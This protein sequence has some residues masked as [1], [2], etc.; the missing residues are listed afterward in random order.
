M[1]SNI[2][3]SLGKANAYIAS[4]RAAVEPEKYLYKLTLSPTRVCTTIQTAQIASENAM[5][6]KS[7]SITCQM[8]LETTQINHFH[9]YMINKDLLLRRR[10]A[11]LMKWC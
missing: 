8:A 3:N 10:T 4:L 9:D 11:L 1:Q 7:L 5:N 6:I 2:T